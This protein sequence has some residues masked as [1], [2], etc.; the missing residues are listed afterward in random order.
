MSNII[1][2]KIY[3]EASKTSEGNHQISKVSDQ[4]RIK[5][6]TNK[7]QSE[8]FRKPFFEEY[9][10]TQGILKS[11][12]ELSEQTV[13]ALHHMEHDHQSD[14]T[15]GTPDNLKTMELKVNRSALKNGRFDIELYRSTSRSA[16]GLLES[17]SNG[18]QM[19]CVAVPAKK[20]CP[21]EY[22][23]YQD[24]FY[25]IETKKLF[26]KY[27]REQFEG[28]IQFSKNPELNAVLWQCR[29]D[30]D[31]KSYPLFWNEFA[32]L[33]EP[34]IFKEIFANGR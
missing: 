26:D 19:F 13:I 4:Y 5:Y 32:D 30:L 16:T 28:D 18:T 23:M 2:P 8:F 7:K 24:R 10:A 22:E 6:N 15:I 14:L 17:V 34:E 20:H 29:I 21:S 9:K 27:L 11:M 12:S 25:I 33:T 3:P 31:F 1:I